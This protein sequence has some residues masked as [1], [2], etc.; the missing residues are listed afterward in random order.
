MPSRQDRYSR[1]R[2]FIYIM[3]SVLILNKKL[4]YQYQY[5]IHI[6]SH[7][8]PLYNVIKNECSLAQWASV[9]LH[10]YVH[11]M[12]RVD[13]IHYLRWQVKKKGFR[14]YARQAGRTIFIIFTFL[15]G[16]K[17]CKSFVQFRQIL[18]TLILKND[19]YFIS[20]LDS[21]IQLR[22]IFYTMFLK[23]LFGVHI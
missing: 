14:F 11:Y 7:H 1:I 2:Y 8:I 5:I 9:R 19:D 23:K 20:G 12:I 18:K 4:N 16:N 15:R 21:F 22:H 10:I 3:H 13:H 6:Y 17:I